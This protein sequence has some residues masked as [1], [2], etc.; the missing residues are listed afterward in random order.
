MLRLA[1]VISLSLSGL[2]YGQ[3]DSLTEV[4][5][6]ERKRRFDLFGGV[7]VDWHR[8]SLNLDNET[9]GRL[10]KHF[11]SLA[12]Q[13]HEQWKRAAS[14]DF[15]YFYFA[16]KK[17]YG[18]DGLL[19]G[20]RD[21]P[22]PSAWAEGLR[23]FLPESTAQR[24]DE[25]LA[26]RESYL[27]GLALEAMVG[28]YEQRVHL[29]A[30]QRPEV[31]KALRRILGERL[32]QPFPLY[33]ERTILAHV[34][35]AE[36]VR[37]LGEDAVKVLQRVSDEELRLLKFPVKV[38][39]VSNDTPE[40]RGENLTA[41][42]KPAVVR[43]EDYVARRIKRLTEQFELSD[44][45]NQKLTIA[46]K[47][48][49]HR[50]RE[51]WLADV[52]DRMTEMG[53]RVRSRSDRVTPMSLRTTLSVSIQEE[54]IWVRTVNS[55]L[56]G[57]GPDRDAARSGMVS[58]MMLALDQELWLLPDQ[59]AAFRELA[60]RAVQPL[61]TNH[62]S[63]QA[64][65]ALS[66]CLLDITPEA[67]GRVLTAKQLKVWSELQ[68]LPNAPSRNQARMMTRELGPRGR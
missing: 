18:A 46:A 67:L 64:N 24:L 11:R 47:G 20:G 14:D 19:R 38:R 49:S 15:R 34:K 37:A 10:T 35:D 26:G 39:C 2:T 41:G 66:Q 6:K 63:R 13:N 53:D 32:T 48:M 55:V 62:I 1:A 68:Q 59:R 12:A 29:T 51:R 50:I 58:Q 56:V 65:A 40:Q 33:S 44:T 9:A 7:C 5:L 3:N 21:E 60:N 54:P 8:V 17:A 45:Q 16:G 31:A 61:T 27:E 43:L 57:R 30:D 52:G 28:I 42:I 4:R 23:Q 25:V 36:L 22:G